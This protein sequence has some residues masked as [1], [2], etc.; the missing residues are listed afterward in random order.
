LCYRY[1]IGHFSIFYTT[2]GQSDS[3]R[4]RHPVRQPT[5]RKAAGSC[6][7][8]RGCPAWRQRCVNFDRALGLLREDHRNLLSHTSDPAN[9]EEAVDAIHGRYPTAF[10]QM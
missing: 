7:R 10:G 1:T 9:F 5:G 8:A 3:R 4:P 6:V 2:P